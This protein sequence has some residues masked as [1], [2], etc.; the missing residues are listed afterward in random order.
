MATQVALH[1]NWLSRDST[2][3][4]ADPDPSGNICPSSQH[5]CYTGETAVDVASKMYL[6]VDLI[7]HPWL[8][9]LGI[10]TPLLPH[11]F[12]LHST[13]NFCC[14]YSESPKGKTASSTVC[15]CP[16]TSDTFSGCPRC[17]SSFQCFSSSLHIASNWV[18]LQNPSLTVRGFLNF[19]CRST[20]REESEKRR[21]E[22]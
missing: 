9:N 3:R 19:T 1:H 18:A 20:K 6:S 10:M 4:S 8:V 13:Y 17:M 14:F 22:W 15:C 16:S 7:E 11:C 5:F 2:P 12:W 21:K